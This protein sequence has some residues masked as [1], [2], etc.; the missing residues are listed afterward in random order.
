MYLFIYL[1][2]STIF[3]LKNDTKR[4]YYKMMYFLYVMVLI[5]S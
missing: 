2:K 5:N 4:E 3:Q 1:L